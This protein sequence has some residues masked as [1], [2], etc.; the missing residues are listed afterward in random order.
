VVAGVGALTALF[1]ATIAVA[2]YDI[3]K[4]LAYSTISQLGFMVAAAGA[5]AYAAAM[6]H[7][8]AHAFFKALLFLG[9]GSV[10]IGLE[11]AHHPLPEDGG[12]EHAEGD[13]H[14]AASD[15]AKG[16]EHAAEGHVFDPNDMRGMGGI[17]HR[18]PVTFWVYLIGSLALAGIPPFAGF[19]SKDEILTDLNESNLLFYLVLTAAAFFTAFYVG[20]QI[21]MVFTGKAR[22]K[23]AAGALESPRLITIPL[24]ILAVLTVFGGGFN[25]P[26]LHFLSSFLEATLEEIHIAEFNIQ[27]ALISTG[28]AA[29]GLTLGWLLYGRKPL[30]AGQPDP[31]SRPLGP[32][33]RLLE[34]KYWVDEI[35][36]AVFI[37]PYIAISRFLADV[38]DW[39]FL[40]NWVHDRLFAAG[41][42]RLSTFLAT[43]IDLGV[44]DRAAN[45]I[46]T[47]TKAMAARMR[48]IQTG[49]VRNYAL[50]VFIGVVILVS[51][52]VL[53]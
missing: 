22:S 13:H 53:R 49:F 17:R 14:D 37:R 47:G 40:H 29:I 24:I 28:V 41:Y 11:R 23:A 21:F 20:R 18:M 25:F 8:V 2:Q 9:A 38:V 16:A 36:Q 19:F 1:A 3:K 30:E 35:Y 10:I 33:F 4:V 45:G 32:V 5:G 51:Y 43:S 34:H 39:R 6:F 31:L 46:A 27:V 52:L 7:L 50:A 15:H 12:H 44:I 48:G 42:N 26:G